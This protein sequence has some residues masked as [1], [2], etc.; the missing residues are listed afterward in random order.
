[1]RN[2]N[3]ESA[4][5]VYGLAGTHTAVLSF[6]FK[7]KPDGLLGFAIERK[8][9]QTGRRIWLEGQKCFKSVIPDP[10]RGQKYPTYL[11]PIQSFLWKDF[12]LTPGNSYTYKITPLFGKPDHLQQG[13]ATEL[14]LTA[15]LECND[16]HGVYFNRGVSGSQSYAEHFPEG[17]ISSMD[18]ET[19]EAALRWLSR[20]LFEGLQAF[21]RGAKKGESLFGAFYEFHEPR[22]L[23][24]LGEARDRGVNVSLVVDGK[25]YG[26][27]NRK[28]VHKAGIASLV[29]TWRT[30][31]KIPHNKFLVHCSKNGTPRRVLNGS[32]NISEKGIFGQCN[33][34]HVLND[35]AIAALYLKYWN[36]LSGDPTKSDLTKVTMALQ[37]DIPT[38]DFGENTVHAFL[39]PRSSPAMLNVYATFTEEAT[40]MA[41]GIFPFNVDERFQRAFNLKKPFL[42]YVIVDKASNAFKADDRNLDVVA[43]AYVK[44]PID[45]WLREKSSGSLFYGGTDFVHNKILIVDP[46]GACPKIV[47]GS[48]NFS[49]PS[50]NANDENMLVLSGPAFRREADIYLTEFIRLFDHFSFREWLN[51]KTATFDPFLDEPCPSNSK[52]WVDKYFDYPGALSYKRKMTFKNMVM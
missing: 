44:S 48:A 31:A 24:L 28:A 23:A 45:Q 7:S 30:K 16:Q 46:L 50:M 40:E 33:T 9:E 6:D 19:K 10:V 35:P 2:R 29:K 17:K 3:I 4:L 34:A 12:T 32:T 8:D 51:S 43:G 52:S 1:M 41:C 27:D 18:S 5:E 39:S 20:G 22:T 25:Q 49:V 38:G 13:D 26:D 15:E 14:H 21:I 37:Q 11:H 36:A 42:R 47:V